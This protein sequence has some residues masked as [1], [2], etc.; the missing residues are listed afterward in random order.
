MDYVPAEPGFAWS[1]I[2]PGFLA[3]GLFVAQNGVTWGT[4]SFLLAIAVYAKGLIDVT[5]SRF[6]EVD[7]PWADKRY[8]NWLEE[9]HLLHHW[10]QRYN[11]TIVHPA[12]DFLFG[13]YLA[14]RKYRRELQLA[15]DA[16]ELTVSDV[17]NWRY[18]LIEATPAEYAAFISEAKRHRPSLDKLDRLIG[19]FRTRVQYQPDEGARDL[20]TK[21]LDLERVL[22]PT[23]VPA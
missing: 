3:G 11:F 12:M 13:S 23:A 21:A 9:I 22:K 7:H 17:I 10:D 2:A 5:H 20:L 19:I 4:A 1:W 16:G 15:L 18:L 8:F 6:H 14:P